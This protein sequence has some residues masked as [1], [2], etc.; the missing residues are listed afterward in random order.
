MS[1]QELNQQ[2]SFIGR[3]LNA[4]Q[5]LFRLILVLGIV[6]ATLWALAGVDLLWPMTVGLRAIAVMLVLAELFGGAWWVWSAWRAPQPPE[7][8]AVRL[9]RAFPEL[10]NHLINYV[11]FARLPTPDRLVR[12][13]LERDIPGWQ[14]VDWRR[15][16]DRR[17]QRRA[18]FALVGVVVLWGVSLAWAGHAWTNSLARILNPFAARSASAMAQFLDVQPGTVAVTQGRAVELRCR[19]ETPLPQEIV[20]ELTPSDGRATTIVLGTPSSRGPHEFSYRLPR[21]TVPVAYRFRAGA[22][23]TARHEIRVL[24]PLAWSELRAQ[25]TP[26]AYMQR[27]SR[28]FDALAEP[29]V[30]PAGSELTLLARANREVAGVFAGGVPAQLERGV[31]RVSVPLGERRALTLFARTESG[32]ELS[33]ELRLLIEPDR[34]PQIRVLQPRGRT[35]QPPDLPARIHWE[36]TDD[37]GL[38]RVA[39][40]SDDGTVVAEWPM[41]REREYVGQWSGPIGQYRIVAQDDRQHSRSPLLIFEEVK[42]K[43]ISEAQARRSTETALTLQQLVKMQRDNLAESAR[44]EAGGATIPA[45]PW[46][47]V[48]GTQSTIRELTGQLLRDP[49]KP[50]GALTG[51]IHATHAGPMLEVLDVLDRVTKSAGDR[52]A[53]HVARAVTLQK[54]ILRALTASERS[55][56]AVERHRQVTGL[57]AMLDTLVATQEAIVKEAR[58]AA[59]SAGPSLGQREDRLAGDVNDFV[60]LAREEAPR[61]EKHDAE[62]ARRLRAVADGCDSRQVAADLLRAAE[63]FEAQQLAQGLP[64]AERALAALREF[65]ALLNEWRIEEAREKLAQVQQVVSQSREKFSKLTELQ[66]KIVETLRQAVTA[67]DL[68]AEETAALEEELTALKENVRAAA[69]KIADD[70]HIFPEL[71]VGNELVQ[72]ISTIFEEVRQVPGS[73]RVPADELGLQ[74]EDFI[75]EMMESIKERF[76]DMEMWL[77]AKPDATRRLTENF[78]QVEMPKMD[79]LKLPEELQDIIGEML[80]QQKEIEEKA[81]DSATNQA[82]PDIP[83]GWDV[84]EGEW[85]SF[86]AKGKSGNEAPDHKAQDGRS[87]VGRQ[88]MSDGETVAGT[89]KINQGDENLENRHTQ[90]PAQAGQVVEEKHTDAV[91]TG[92]GKLSGFDD[93][94][95]QPGQ[96]PRRDANLPGSPLG[97]QAML[98]RQAEALYARASLLHIRTGSLDE[99]VRAMRDAEEAMRDGRSIQQI[100]ELQRRVVATLHEAQADLAAGFHDMVVPSSAPS[101]PGVDQLAGV[102]DEAPPQYRE[103]VA[104]YFKSLSAGP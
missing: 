99:V 55:Y 57:L 50:L 102:P 85:S 27:P 38:T 8:V 64:F 20:L 52:R 35:R 47:R 25:V 90:D 86:S 26:P 44:L 88:G 18:N 67:K 84:M 46:M 80:E 4:W 56:D 94:F 17:R 101:A 62:L 16:R 69:L 63:Q 3:Q 29:V 1:V 83:M 75:L 76:D 53:A 82:V 45:A 100:R 7:A 31:W 59:P 70:L 93:E 72:D 12:A 49:R 10:D 79:A 60:A 81:H 54:E 98:R 65:Q 32:E 39:V 23:R 77:A 103:L 43:E 28:T 61:F 73:D 9:E 40:E 58:A 34:P 6:L 95:G 24:P 30:V 21:V 2:L 92:G 74:K 11:Q 78:D 48:L 33:T 13:Y 42:P 68:S 15:L 71:P 96:G 89:G 22:A 41:A 91:A 5:M 97:L 36:V 66:A 104:E 19:V 37:F 51:L 14:A 87:L